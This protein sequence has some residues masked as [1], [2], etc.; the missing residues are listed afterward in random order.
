MKKGKSESRVSKTSSLPLISVIVPI[1]KV[2]KYLQNC[3]E[4]I[5][6]Q[7]Y[8]RLEIILVDDGSPDQCPRMCDE[9]S[10]NDARIKVVHKENG[11]LVSARKAGVTIATGDYI[12]YV[13]GD[14]WVMPTLYMELY[15]KGLQYDADIVSCA[16]YVK[17]YADNSSQVI[18]NE[19]GN[20][21]YFK[22]EFE[23]KVFPHLIN[24]DCFYNTEIPQ[25]LCAHAFKKDLLYRNQMK[26]D[27]F[28]RMAEDLICVSF[29]FME[30]NSVV[31]TDICGYCYRLSPDSMTQNH[32]E[33]EVERIEKLYT[34]YQQRILEL[35]YEKIFTKKLNFATI[36]TLLVSNYRRLMR[37]ED[38]LLFPFS[39]VRTGDRVIVY[40]AGA[41][42]KELVYFLDND[43]RFK[44][45]LWVDTA[46]KKYQEQGLNVYS[47]QAIFSVEFDYVVLAVTKESISKQISIELVNM[48]INKEKV[49]TMDLQMIINMRNP[50][51]I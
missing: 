10:E 21:L 6:N 26:I 29:C 8:Q 15:E 49:Q 25:S 42:G 4:S 19:L 32:F 50:L 9:F 31:L 51:N 33:D 36:Y 13:D 2:E 34:Q 5:Q 18:K 27:N 40:G 35:S 47:P 3:V 39:K 14:D 46:Y 12:V 1:Y 17:Y 37:K 38:E 28:I 16:G 30:A 23:E 11:G 20:N 48:G 44:L 7:T 45:V 24:T 41:F 43:K 22:E